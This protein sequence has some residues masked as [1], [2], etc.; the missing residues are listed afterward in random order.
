MISHDRAFLNQLVGSIVEIRQ[1]K[2][3]RYRG[4]YDDY[5][6]QREAARSSNWP[7][8]RTSSAKSRR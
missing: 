2:L 6:A 4:N 5:L 7:P 3:I 8:T 1:G